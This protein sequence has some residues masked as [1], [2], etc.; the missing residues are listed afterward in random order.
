MSTSGRLVYGGDGDAV[1]T[2]E[3]VG[4]IRIVL[5]VPISEE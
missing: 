5:V 3:V 4:Q 1:A 2:A